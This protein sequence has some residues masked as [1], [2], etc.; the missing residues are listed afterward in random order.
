MTT[1][2]D[3]S[4]LV[5]DRIGVFPG[6]VPYR[7]IPSLAIADGANIDLSAVHSTLHVGAHADAPSHY[8][9]GGLH[10]AARPLELYYGPCQVV[11]VAAG[12]GVRLLPESLDT[13]IEAPRVLFKTGTFPDPNVFNED[14]A[15]L[16]P[17]LV[18]WLHARGV[19]LVGIDTPSI[20]P[21]HDP[22]LESHQA[23]ARHDMAILEG[24]VLAHVPAGVYTLVAL[25]LR[26]DGADAS[27][28]R[29]ALVRTTP[30]FPG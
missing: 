27:P 3:I 23:I 12:R 21:C 6:D 13:A 16:S 4:P 29:A 28:V 18:D 15:S 5:T 8:A 26:L 22:V 25:P 11:D 2:L 10:I 30:A 7:R 17:A 19:R 14:F 20:D 1:I 24:L 9:A